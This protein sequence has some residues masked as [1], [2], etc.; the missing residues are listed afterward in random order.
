MKKKKGTRILAL[1]LAVLLTV[2]LVAAGIGS[3]LQ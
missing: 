3:F 2:G 1:I